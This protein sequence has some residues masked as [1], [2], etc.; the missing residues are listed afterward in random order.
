MGVFYEF[1]GG[2]MKPSC[3]SYSIILYG[4]SI[5]R[6]VIY[7]E[8][9]KK[10]VV[11]KQSFASSLSQTFNCAFYNASSFGNTLI[12]GLRN[13]SKDIE[14]RKPNI[15]VLEF[16]GNDCDFQWDEVAEKPFDKHVPNTN[17]STFKEHLLEA[18][19]QL[20]LWNIFPVFLSLPPLVST[21][22]LKWV[23]NS[24]SR[25]MN[26]ILSWLGDV[27]QISR[28]QSMYNDAIITIAREAN[29]RWIDIRKAF[30]DQKNF[31]DY[32]CVDGIHPNSKGHQL[33]TDHI[34]GYI[35]AD[36]SF[37]LKSVK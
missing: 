32:M 11:T 23:G 22:Y 9:K 6:G 14:K 17:L 15:V 20:K 27:E 12:R 19:E 37:L 7:D 3:D 35:K 34:L 33:I 16:G 29:I 2:M 8:E 4:D 5:S 24:D 30:L 26:R 18:L 36:Y 25:K 1:H 21:R 13:L 10:Y 28:W 31:E